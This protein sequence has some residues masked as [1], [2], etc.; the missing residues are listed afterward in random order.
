[1]CNVNTCKRLARAL[2]H[3]CQQDLCTDHLK[4]HSDILN[5]QLIPLADKINVLFEEL[6]NVPLVGHSFTTELDKWCV[7]AHREVDFCYERKTQ[8]FQEFLHQ[9][10]AKKKSGLEQL[11]NEVS[12]LIYEQ[13]TTR[14]NISSIERSIHEQTDQ[15]HP[16]PFT[17]SPFVIDDQFIVIH[18]N[19]FRLN[20]LRRL[21]PLFKPIREKINYDCMAASDNHLV[22][23][24][25]EKLC[26][27]DRQLIVQQEIPW[28][29]DRLW[30]IIW[31]KTLELFFLITSEEIFILDEK[32]MTVGQ[33]PIIR[34]DNKA[35]WW[36]GTCINNTLFISSMGRGVSI[37]EY[38][39]EPVIQLIKEYRSPISCNADEEIDDLS[40]NSSVLAIVRRNSQREVRIDLCS[41][42]T[43]ERYRSIQLSVIPGH[44]R[45]RSCSLMT[46]HWIVIIPN[47]ELYYISA[48][49]KLTEKEN[50]N[51]T[52]RHVESFGIHSLVILTNESVNLHR[53]S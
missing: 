51:S 32:T 46:D 37:Y 29:H 25:N 4:N 2:C 14:E 33:R 50:Y 17:F 10:R 11:R 16:H 48:D 30:D 38:I 5:S 9:Q 18:H 15:F 24:L 7:E 27:L 36:C 22:V 47:G 20:D 23:I 31:S 43:L 53:L 3:C 41:S 42:K 26:L 45:V 21:P 44:R 28:N 39:L 49:G 52:P 1:M 34:N 35:N 8:E 40:S 19:T 6:N 13:E 12:T